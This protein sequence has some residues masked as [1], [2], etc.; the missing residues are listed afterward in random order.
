MET[1][2]KKIAW[3]TVVV[4]DWLRKR[5]GRVEFILPIV[6]EAEDGGVF[7]VVST[8]AIAE[9]LYVESPGKSEDYQIISEFFDSKEVWTQAMD[10]SVAECARDI[11][12]AHD[13]AGADSLHIATA[14]VTGSRFLLTNDGDPPKSRKKPMLPLDQKIK[15]LTSGDLLRIMTPKAYHDMRVREQNPIID[16]NKPQNSGNE[17]KGEGK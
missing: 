11:R 10:R 3:D 15:M 6:K 12:R 17:G 8:M 14:L 16:A 5:K 9:T 2:R 4:L 1:E 13:I 7:I